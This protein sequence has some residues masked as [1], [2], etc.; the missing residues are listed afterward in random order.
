MLGKSAGTTGHGRVLRGDPARN[1]HLRIAV[2]IASALKM[3][4]CLFARS[5]GRWYSPEI[6]SSSMLKKSANT[7]KVEASAKV[8]I[9]RV[10]SSL[11]L[12]LDL[13]LF[14]SSRVGP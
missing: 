10:C 9:K 6:L 11:N 8:E 13:S 7:K 1:T 4:H 2:A 14:R 5:P 12:N 3:T